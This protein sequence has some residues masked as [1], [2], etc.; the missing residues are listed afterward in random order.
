[1]AKIVI[2]YRRTDS[3][4]TGR[5]FDRLVQRYGKDSVFRD[6]DNIPF[7]IDFRKVIN[8][9]LHG[10]DVLIAIVGPNWRG[11]RKQG[12]ARINDDND[13]VR[14]E[15]ETALQREIPVIP[16]LVGGAI[17]PKPTELPD[18]LR[19]FLFRNA[20]NI[21]SGRN[22]DTDI[23]RL[24]RSMDSLLEGKTVETRPAETTSSGGRERITVPTVRS[25]EPLE[26]ATPAPGQSHHWT[27]PKRLSGG[28]NSEKRPRSA[29]KHHRGV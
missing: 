5:I 19:D 9:A 22:F 20:A 29:P 14:I 2:S 26:E 28:G 8:D 24:M 18:S 3:D 23:E 27:S 10:T 6:I 17:M 21:D 1:M 4:V 13:L 12:S 16:A 25:Q 7:G 11:T 15:V